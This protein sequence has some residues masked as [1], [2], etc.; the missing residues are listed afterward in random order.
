MLPNEWVFVHSE[1]Y[2]NMTFQN[3]M[4]KV[5]LTDKRKFCF[6]SIEEKDF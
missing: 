2:F 1:H 4:R 6:P 3:V 5:V